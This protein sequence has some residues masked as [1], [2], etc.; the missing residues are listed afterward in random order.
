MIYQKSNKTN[1]SPAIEE[2]KVRRSSYRSF[3]KPLRALRVLCA[4]CGIITNAL[5]AIKHI[6]VDT[7]CSL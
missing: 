3:Q 5:A 7:L 4:L 2:Q 1:K 6:S